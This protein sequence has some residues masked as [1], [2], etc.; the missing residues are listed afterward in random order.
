VAAAVDPVE[1]KK[2]LE[3]AEK[4]GVPIKAIYTTHHHWDH[5]GGNEE[6]LK[7]LPAGTPVYGADDRSMPAPPSAC[8]RTRVCEWVGG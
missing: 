2:V 7:A 8:V 5:A 3:A 6:L 4:E 1:P